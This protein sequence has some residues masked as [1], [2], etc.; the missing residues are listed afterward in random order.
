MEIII[1]SIKA[2]PLAIAPAVAVLV[3]IGLY[4]LT[5]RRN[6]LND[7]KKVVVE[8]LNFI[9]NNTISFHFGY[10]EP[11]GGGKGGGGGSAKGLKLTLFEVAD[12]HRFDKPYFTDKFDDSP[13]FFRKKINQIGDIK[14]F[15]NNPLLPRD[16][17][18]AIGKFYNLRYDKA[19]YKFI[20]SREDFVKIETGF[21]D[22]SDPYDNAD[23]DRSD[24]KWGN[25]IAFRSF[26]SFKECC[27]KLEESIAYWNKV[28]KMRLEIRNDKNGR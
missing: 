12:L 16:I 23:N 21:Y 2:N 3:A 5:G 28:N 15:L 25:T 13:V 7:Q 20:Q 18:T 26:L 9:Q 10:W 17:S 4:I 27:L 1:E 8:L 11:S 22:S 6:R 19:D 24:L 14:R